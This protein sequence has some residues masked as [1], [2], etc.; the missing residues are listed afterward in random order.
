M[1]LGYYHRLISSRM[2]IPDGRP[3]YVLRLGQ[4]DVKGLLKSI[5]E[6]G[7]LKLVSYTLLHYY[8]TIILIV[9]LYLTFYHA[10]AAAS[11]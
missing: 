6:D 8:Y 2:L 11:M 5:G 10:P 1:L 4:M 3:L 7:L 9:H